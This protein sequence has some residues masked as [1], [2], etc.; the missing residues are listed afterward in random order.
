MLDNSYV[1]FWEK[2]LP[3]TYIIDKYFTYT[4]N[5]M[6]SDM[7][8]AYT[9]LRCR[10]VAQRVRALLGKKSKYEIG[11]ELIC[12]VYLYKD[13]V[14]FNVNIRY[15]V[16]DINSSMITIQNIKDTTK[17]H[18]LHEDVIDKH[19]IYRYCAT[20]HSCQGAS[21]KSKITIH[22]REKKNLVTREW[23]WTCITRATD[24]RSVYFF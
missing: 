8:I 18:T 15:K 1:D 5:V 14:I 9:N 2:K 20:C 10:S 6:T 4:D 11:E 17:K 16:I 23:L 3:M 13:G 24:F 19:F 22:E 7:H 12:R 21:I